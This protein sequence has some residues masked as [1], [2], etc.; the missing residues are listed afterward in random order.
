MLTPKLPH[1]DTRVDLYQALTPQWVALSE[2]EVNR[3]AN[4]ANLSA[5]M[6]AAFDWHWVGFYLVDAQRD[7]LVL[8][9]FQGPVACT[10]LHHGKGVCAAAWDSKK[11]QVVD[12]VHDF[13]GHIACSA[14]SI[15]ELVM[16]VVVNGEVVAVLDIDSVKVS[17]FSQVDVDGL[18]A[19]L[20]HLAAHWN[21]WE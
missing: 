20:H 9:P 5:A 13:P 18:T 10:R 6:Y 3:T 15:S 1:A 8:G 7:E 4:L 19:I 16:P 21:H 14:L 12:N 17:G 11:A 2:G